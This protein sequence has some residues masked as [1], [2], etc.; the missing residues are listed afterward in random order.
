MQACIANKEN[1]L[2]KLVDI[3]LQ[4]RNDKQIMIIL[5]LALMCIEQSSEMRPTMSEVVSVLTEDK[6]IDEIFKD[7]LARTSAKKTD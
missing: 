7:I 2:L 3:S 4:Q 6:T 1:N 5:K